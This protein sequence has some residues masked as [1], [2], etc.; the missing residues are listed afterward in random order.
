[1]T[2]SF[3]VPKMEARCSAM[4]HEARLRQQFL[5][6]AQ[7]GTL[8]TLLKPLLRELFPPLLSCNGLLGKK[9]GDLGQGTISK[10]PNLV[11]E[12]CHAEAECPHQD[13]SMGDAI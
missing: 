2:L 8:L 1:M 6:H 5:H 11:S 10:D 12:R 9:D 7:R 4:L 13:T 3:S